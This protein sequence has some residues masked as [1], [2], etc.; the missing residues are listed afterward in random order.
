RGRYVEFH[1]VHDKGT[2]FGLN[3]PGSRVGSILI[4]LPTTAQW[5]YMH[6]GPEPDTSERKPLEVLRELKEWI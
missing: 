5:R 3:V 4:S 2:A 6:D 1:L